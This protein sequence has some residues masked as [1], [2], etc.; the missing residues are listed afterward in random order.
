MPYRPRSLL[1]DV[2]KHVGKPGPWAQLPWRILGMLF[3]AAVLM[4]SQPGT[5]TDSARDLPAPANQSHAPSF[6]GR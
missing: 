2:P 1:R 5:T 6:P 3:V 4:T